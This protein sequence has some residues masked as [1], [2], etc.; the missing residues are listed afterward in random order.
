[1]VGL[2]RTGRVM[3]VVVSRLPAGILCVAAGRELDF[4]EGGRRRRAHPDHMERGEH[5]GL[6]HV[7]E[8]RRNAQRVRDSAHGWFSLTYPAGEVKGPPGWGCTTPEWD[9]Q[10]RASVVVFSCGLLCRK[11]IGY[12]AP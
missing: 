8:E 9:C 11:T 10:P 4:R 1:V 12:S 3:A 2:V 7:E 6:E 5:P